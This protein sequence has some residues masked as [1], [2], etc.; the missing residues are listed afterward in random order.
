MNGPA[1][2]TLWIQRNTAVLGLSATLLF[3]ILY[4][5]ASGIGNVSGSYAVFI[6]AASMSSAFSI[7]M[8]NISKWIDSGWASFVS[9]SSGRPEAGPGSMAAAA[10]VPLLLNCFLMIVFSFIMPRASYYIVSGILTMAV[11]FS[12]LTALSMRHY[13][14]TGSSSAFQHASLA[15]PVLGMLVIFVYIF[16]IIVPNGILCISLLIALAI[17]IAAMAAANRF[18]PGYYMI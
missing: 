13:A 3:L 5:L 16:N 17:I 18:G 1:A 11:L 14:G 4:C 8:I 9:S 2:A 12:F 7:A 15:S 10:F 6:A